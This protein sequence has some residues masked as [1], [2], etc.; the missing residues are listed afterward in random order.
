MY[1]SLALNLQALCVEPLCLSVWGAGQPRCEDSKSSCW[2][3]DLNFDKFTAW[4]GDEKGGPLFRDFEMMLFDAT[5]KQHN[6]SDCRTS[7]TVWSFSLFQMWTSKIELFQ[8]ERQRKLKPE[9]GMEPSH[10]T[11]TNESSADD[12]PT[13]MVAD[14]QL[15][16]SL[17]SLSSFWGLHVD[18]LDKNLWDLQASSHSCHI[19]TAVSTLK[20]SACFEAA[21]H[22]TPWPCRWNLRKSA[23]IQTLDQTG[24]GCWPRWVQVD[25]AAQSLLGAAGH[26]ARTLLRDP[27]ALKNS[28]KMFEQT[29]FQDMWCIWS[30]LSGCI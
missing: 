11:I 22:V 28:R 15:H 17:S 26:V 30:T 18:Q 9:R 5:K 10:E 19:S 13:W 12:F 14:Y 20:Y 21:A 16:S 8:V 23:V 1:D 7:Q 6:F 2:G 25:A 24:C 27:S 3:T 29:W 4:V